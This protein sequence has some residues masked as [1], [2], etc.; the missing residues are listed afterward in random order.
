[1]MSRYF[2]KMAFFQKPTIRS[3]I[4]PKPNLKRVTSMLVMF[5]EEEICW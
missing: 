5:V 1:M 2:V 4:Q 3:H